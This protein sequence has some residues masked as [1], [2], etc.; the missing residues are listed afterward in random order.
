MCYVT[1]KLGNLHEKRLKDMLFTQ[2]HI[3]AARNAFKLNCPN[4]HCAYGGRVTG[5][6][7]TRRK[8]M[9]A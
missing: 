2:T 3:D 8:Y 1:F 6:G 7:P 4:C 9:T 5:H